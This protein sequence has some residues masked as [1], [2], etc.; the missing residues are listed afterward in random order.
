MQEVNK[1]NITYFLC[2]FIT[3]IQ[4]FTLVLLKFVLASSILK[5]GFPHLR[6]SPRNFHVEEFC[7]LEEKSLSQ[8]LN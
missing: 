7:E 2:L 3:S 5:G 1:L 8:S 6:T 4:F